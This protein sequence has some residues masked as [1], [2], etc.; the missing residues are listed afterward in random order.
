[1][2][3]SSAEH[4]L[5]LRFDNAD[6]RLARKGYELGLLPRETYE[7]TQHKIE[8]IEEIISFLSS[9]NISPEAAKVILP[10]NDA[11][12]IGCNLSLYK[13]LCR[14]DVALASLVPFLSS[15]I[16]NKIAHFPR[17]L[18]RLS[19]TSNMPVILNIVKP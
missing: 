1:M 17:L 15:E 9:T 12:S 11:H 14:P 10:N 16:K 7:S 18:R 3:T 2:F 8:V 5:M 6:R 13:L 19:V 4:R